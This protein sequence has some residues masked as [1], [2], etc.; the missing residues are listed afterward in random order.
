MDSDKRRERQSA[1]AVERQEEPNAKILQ[2]WCE[3]KEICSIGGCNEAFRF[4]LANEV[5]GA[6]ERKLRALL[7]ASFGMVSSSELDAN[8]LAHEFDCGIIEKAELAKTKKNYKDY[9]WLSIRESDDPPLKVIRGL[10]L[11]PRGLI[12]EIVENW[13]KS[14]GWVISSRKDPATGKRTDVCYRPASVEEEEE[15]RG[16]LSADEGIDSEL[17]LTTD[18]HGHFVTSFR[19]EPQPGTAIDMK[20]PDTEEAEELDRW[21][22]DLDYETAFR[23]VF[24]VADAA[25]LFAKA[26]GLSPTTDEKVLAFAGIK[27]GAVS[28]RTQGYKDKVRTKL[29][30]EVAKELDA[31]WPVATAALLK[32][33]RKIILETQTDSC[34][35]EDFLAYVESQSAAISCGKAFPVEGRPLPSFSDMPF[36]QRGLGGNGRSKYL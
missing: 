9:V 3:W 2:A 14:N 30:K 5:K 12:N 32:T 19:P 1:I 15:K 34:S 28:K 13:L 24:D 17:P 31:G 10:L 6:F 35:G 8:C 21:L 18:K 36:P 16:T 29:D 7:G 23:K 11:G 27:R 22:D 25:I 4:V 20:A 33:A 26:F